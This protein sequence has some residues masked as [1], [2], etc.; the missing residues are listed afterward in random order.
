[1][2]SRL[3]F[4]YLL[5]AV[6]VV[7][8]IILVSVEKDKD[9]FESKKEVVEKVKAEELASIEKVKLND[10]LNNEIRDIDLNYYLYCVTA[11]E[12]PFKYEIEA[13]KAQVIVARTYLYNKILTNGEKDADV[14]TDY[15]HCQAYLELDQLEEIWKDKGYSDEEIAVGERKI[16]EAV[17]STTGIVIM[18][19]GNIIDALFHASSPVCTENAK[20]IWSNEDVP[21]LKSVKNVEDEEYEN[22]QSEVVVDYVDFKNA[23]VA[24]KY[25]DSVTIE[26][27]RTIHINDYTETGRVKNIAVGNHLVKAEDLRKLF[28]LNS[29]LFELE[30]E[31]TKIKFKV[32]GFGH[33]V[34]MSQVGANH[35]AKNG[36]TYS[37]ILHYYYTDVDIVEMKRG[38]I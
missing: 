33:G 32:T 22:R 7:I 27:F 25:V 13:I 3:Y 20:A 30:V 24:K 4:L 34:G 8:I 19:K 28:G 10:V 17:E 12:I 38:D 15:R 37:D 26:D 14:C 21:Y 35:L 9:D 36:Y 16:K 18:Y 6:L 5:S 29:T 1:M 2:K 31:D 11:S 23:L